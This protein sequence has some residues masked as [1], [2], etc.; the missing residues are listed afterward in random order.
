MHGH[1]L[2]TKKQKP[3]SGKCVSFVLISILSGHGYEIRHL[4]SLLAPVYFF[5][6]NVGITWVCHHVLEAGDT[7]NEQ[8]KAQSDKRSK[9]KDRLPTEC[10]TAQPVRAQSLGKP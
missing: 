2:L 6:E 8:H 3:D 9:G 5:S 4:L 10:Q 1:R 7:V